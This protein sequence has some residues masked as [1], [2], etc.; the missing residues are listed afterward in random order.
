MKTVV[1]LLLLT[2]LFAFKP[3]ENKV[4]VCDSKTSV[5]YHEYKDCRGL[6]KCTHEIVY[7][8]K[9]DAVNK[10]GKRACKICY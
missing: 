10:Y 2:C 9:K 4:Y 7:V 5:A 3:G 8:T 1:K 6:Q